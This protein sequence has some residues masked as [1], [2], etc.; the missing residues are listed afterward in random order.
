MAEITGKPSKIIRNPIYP[1][2]SRS[3]IVSY[4]RTRL[5]C[6]RRI[7]ASTLW[8]CNG[9]CAW[10]HR[11]FP[12]KMRPSCDRQAQRV[13]GYSMELGEDDY[14]VF[15]EGR[16]LWELSIL[17]VFLSFCPSVSPDGLARRLALV[18]TNNITHY[19]IWA[20][21]SSIELIGQ[22][23]KPCSMFNSGFRGSM[24]QT[25]RRPLEEGP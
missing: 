17:S 1:A 24:A 22:S 16:D 4:F 11:F 23:W 9:V 21:L 13:V 14:Q 15:A 19:L 20:H 8:V 25:P 7:P 2:M 6:I 5:Q 10:G 18:P 3:D 12:R